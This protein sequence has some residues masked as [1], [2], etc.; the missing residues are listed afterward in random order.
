M[1]LTYSGFVKTSENYT[2]LLKSLLLVWL[3]AVIWINHGWS[4]EP[5]GHTSMIFESKYN[6]FHTRKWI[7]ICRLQKERISCPTDFTRRWK[8]RSLS[9]ARILLIYTTSALS[10]WRHQ[11][12]TIFALLVFLW[13]IHQ[14]PYK[15]QFPVQRPMTGALMFCLMCLE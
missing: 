15:D 6:M 5:Y 1:I 11:M 14:S 12:E 10:G 8:F 2:L 4:I 7:W 13:E 3:Q 9:M